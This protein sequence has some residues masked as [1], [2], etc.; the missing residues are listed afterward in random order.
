MVKF[1][2]YPIQVVDNTAI[3]CIHSVNNKYDLKSEMSRFELN[4]PEK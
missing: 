3:T 1:T 2:K 4:N